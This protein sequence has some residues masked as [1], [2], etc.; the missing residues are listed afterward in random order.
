MVSPLCEAVMVQTPAAI[1]EAVLPDT[2]QVFVV[3]ELKLTDSPEL[4]VAFNVS[5]PPTV[6][7]LIGL[8]VIVCLM[9]KWQADPSLD[10][11]RSCFPNQSPDHN[12]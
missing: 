2:E 12:Q 6:W 1:S 11:R 10:S 8:N 7:L 4:A 3:E 9:V 5:A